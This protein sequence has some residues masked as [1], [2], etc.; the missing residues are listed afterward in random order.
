MY[1]FSSASTE[2]T[3]QSLRLKSMRLNRC[4]FNYNFDLEH[5]TIKSTVCS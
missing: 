1:I 4:D 3:Q 2:N 5:K